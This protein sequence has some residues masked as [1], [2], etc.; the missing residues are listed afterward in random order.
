MF[1]TYWALEKSSLSAHYPRNRLVI[2]SNPVV[3]DGDDEAVVGRE[4]PF[5][6][7]FEQRE[8]LVD[9]SWL[10]RFISAKQDSTKA[11][12]GRDVELK[13]AL[14]NHFQELAIVAQDDATFLPRKV[15]DDFVWSSP[16]MFLVCPND[17]G[18]RSCENG[19][20]GVINIDVNEDLP[21]V[22]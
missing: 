15:F 17:I 7:D 6:D 3:A 10:A 11:R 5:M 18:T 19:A 13:S 14:L 22:S 16:G 1:S 21:G 12:R 8:H 2:E 20:N 9:S 4:T